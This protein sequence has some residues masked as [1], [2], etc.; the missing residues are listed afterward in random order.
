MIRSRGPGVPSAGV[1][2]CEGHGSCDRLT[3]YSST[4][5]W[6][7]SVPL[8]DTLGEPRIDIDAPN[9]DAIADLD[10]RQTLF[11]AVACCGAD[12]DAELLG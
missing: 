11:V 2:I 4:A 3:S 9:I 1:S 7:R 12:G 6:S 10:V 8:N 5:S